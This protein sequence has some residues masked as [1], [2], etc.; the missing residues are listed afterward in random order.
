MPIYFEVAPAASQENRAQNPLFCAHFI[1][2]F[3]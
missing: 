1:I 2:G 3:S